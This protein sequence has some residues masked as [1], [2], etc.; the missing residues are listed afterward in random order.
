M[1]RGWSITLR[2]PLSLYI[3]DELAKVTILGESSRAQN[4][5]KSKG[6][7]SWL[8]YNFMDIHIHRSNLV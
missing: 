1:G 3:Y 4:L 2:Q 8:A 6:D 7:P 5:Y